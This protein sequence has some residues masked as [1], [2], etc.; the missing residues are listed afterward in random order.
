MGSC[1]RFELTLVMPV[2]ARDACFVVVARGEPLLGEVS[3]SEVVGRGAAAHSGWHPAGIDGVADDIRPQP[4]DSY[5]ECRDEELAVGVRAGVLAAPVEIAEARAAAVVLATRE[6]DESLRAVDQ[7]CQQ[8][9]RDDVD[10]EDGRARVDAGVVDDGVHA[11]EVVDL[12]GDSPRFVL[13]CEVAD[14][15]GGATVDEVAHRVGA[16]AVAHVHDNFVPVVDQRFRSGVAESVGGAGD[17]DAGHRSPCSYVISALASAV[18]DF[19]GMPSSPSGCRQ[20]WSAPASRCAWTTAATSSALPCGTIASIRRSDPP[21]AT[22]ASLKPSW[23][24]FW[25]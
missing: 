21:L 4:R 17:E 13:V 11:A 19:L 14:N 10:R 5:R 8:I 20:T 9:R 3:E 25:T 6:V 18:Q 12:I 1:V 22:S 24:R 7:R 16:R 2:A 23:S 15:D